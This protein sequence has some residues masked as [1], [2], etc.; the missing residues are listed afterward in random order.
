MYGLPAGVQVWLITLPP[1]IVV[2]VRGRAKQSAAAKTRK[3]PSVRLR[4]ESLGNIGGPG[5]GTGARG[6][7]TLSFENNKAYRVTAASTPS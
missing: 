1:A 3:A 7:V 6:Y 2:A 5:S 4:N